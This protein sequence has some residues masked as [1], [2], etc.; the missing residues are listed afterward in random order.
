MSEHNLAGL[1]FADNLKRNPDIMGH[2][3]NPEALNKQLAASAKER[4]ALN[5]KNDAARPSEPR[6]E[7]N[8]LRKELFTAQE[9]AKNAEIY[10]NDRAGTVKLLEQRITDLLIKKKGANPLEERN[11]EHQIQ[12]LE[13]ELFD[14]KTE[15]N[16]AAL[17]SSRAG[18]GLKAFS[19]HARIAELKLELGIA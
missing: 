8:Q 4:A 14:A 2:I 17:Q 1:V 11:Y 9:W 6:K 18:R 12:L 7:Y 13:T 16:R 5:A 19:G 3:T 15:L 10:C